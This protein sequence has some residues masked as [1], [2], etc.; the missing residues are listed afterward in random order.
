MKV[1]ARM[2]LNNGTQKKKTKKK[3]QYEFWTTN[4]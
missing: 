1:D 2:T 3:N 4:M